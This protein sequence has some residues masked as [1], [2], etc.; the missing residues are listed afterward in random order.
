MASYYFTTLAA[1]IPD[2]FGTTIPG[3]NEGSVKCDRNM[4][5]APDLAEE[6]TSDVFRK[7]PSC[8]KKLLS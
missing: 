2:C 4:R 1:M 7:P 8:N 6:G 3:P 5:C